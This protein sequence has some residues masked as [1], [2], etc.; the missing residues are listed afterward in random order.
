[1]E[2]ADKIR[3]RRTTFTVTLR[4]TLR[5]KLC[6]ADVINYETPPHYSSEFIAKELAHYFKIVDYVEWLQYSGGEPFLNRELPQMV[7]EA[8]KYQDQFEKLMI[9]ANG[10]ILP[11]GDMLN[12][13]LRHKEKIQFFFSNYGEVSSKG[14]ELM[15]LFERYGLSYKEKKYYGEEQHC[16][17]W[18]DFGGWENRG[19]TKEQ[20][21]SIYD[22]CSMHTMG[23]TVVQ[24]GQMHLCRKS[25]RGMELGAFERQPSD[26]MDILDQATTVQDKRDHLRRMLS[27]PYLTACN[28]C[29][30]TYGTSDSSKRMRPAE[31]IQ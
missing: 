14:T 2:T 5:C 1:M 18:V 25:Y 23:F 9:F 24:E 22:V 11:T 27:L 31:Q 4:C 26:Y 21:T 29:N 16:G 30:A 28:Y 3:L 10:T 20:L 6:S 8:M 13:F 12:T 19:Y 17:G 7:E 15:E